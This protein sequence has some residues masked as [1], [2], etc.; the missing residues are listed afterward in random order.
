MLRLKE[1]AKGYRAASP[2]LRL[3][4]DGTLDAS[5]AEKIASFLYYL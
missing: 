4:F 1:G 5:I 2:A 3:N